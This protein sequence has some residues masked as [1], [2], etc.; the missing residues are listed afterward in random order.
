MAVVRRKSAAQLATEAKMRRMAALPNGGKSPALLATQRKM[1]NAAAARKRAAAATE[2]NKLRQF[3]KKNG[4]IPTLLS[5]ESK[6]RFG[7]ADSKDVGQ[8]GRLVAQGKLTRDEAFRRMRQGAA[9]N[10]KDALRAGLDVSAE[11]DPEINGANRRRE[12]LK[13]QYDRARKTDETDTQRER[14]NVGGI[15]QALSQQLARQPAQIEQ[16]YNQASAGMARNTTSLQEQIRAAYQQANQ[17]TG[18]L[19]RQLGGGQTQAQQMGAA[20]QAF[21][22][23]L[24]GVQNQGQQGL[25]ATGRT[26]ALNDARAT[27]NYASFEGANTQATMLQE[28][29]RRQ[30]E[31]T[32]EFGDEDYELAGGAS[33]LEETRF[34]QLY[35]RRRA[36]ESERAEA[37]AEA[38]DR[39]FER[40]LA[41]ARLQLDVGELD[42]KR[43]NANNQARLAEQR[44]RV[45]M[46]RLGLDRARVDILAR[47]TNAK[48]LAA[49]RKYTPGTPEYQEVQ[50]AIDLKRA[51]A[52]SGRANAAANVSRAM[53]ARERE[54]RAAATPPK[55]RPQDFG[56][57]IGGAQTYIRS[58]TGDPG[59]Q[60]AMQ[61]QLAFTSSR[62]PKYEQ[63][64][65]QLEDVMKRRNYPEHIRG[66]MRR[67]IGIYYGRST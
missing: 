19:A 66:V 67:M 41:Q 56:K 22:T 8:L 50:A 33:D 47:Q 16:V 20:D 2:T 11:I 31:R 63:A 59:W 62:F 52:A 26:G 46:E 23:S 43:T 37:Q 39:A 25:L 53:T 55:S 28:L 36:L 24:A 64:T 13:R 10:N 14:K 29:L 54:A 44:I 5:N 32:N 6:R 49:Q 38:E 1:R 61:R 58:A 3:Y 17:Q 45:D 4:H 18:D 15:Y 42:V 30:S 48:L 51:Q 12:I 60:G 34:A 35:E 21:L 27:Q 57:G 9:V 7:E 40:Q 65:R